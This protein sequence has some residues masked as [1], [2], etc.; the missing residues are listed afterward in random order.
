MR[1][2][3]VGLAAAATVSIA[4][5]AAGAVGHSG[6]TGIVAERMEFMESL[7]DAMKS[8]TEMMRGEEDFDAER[9]RSL[10]R[11]IG[12]HGGEAL[13]SLFPEGSLDPPTEA[14][15]V[16]WQDWERF[17][18]LADQLSA[19]AAALEA[20]AGNER[21][22]HGMQGMTGGGMVPGGGMTAGRGPSMMSA[23]STGPS[24]EHLAE[25][26]PDAA[27]R[28]LTQTCSACHEDFRMEQ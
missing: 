5:V 14:L 26:L 1:Y 15:P 10:A 11:T 4:L 2:M 16:I 7:G 22:G 25:M 13:T 20:A 24:A 23:G 12:D 27:F 21:A 18:S 3:E 28:H 8:L 19:Y 17:S 9:V 6:A